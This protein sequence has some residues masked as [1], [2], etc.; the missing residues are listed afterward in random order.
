[1]WPLFVALTVL[2]AVIG[3]A[4][5]LAGESQG[6]GAAALL[7]AIFNLLAIVL[8][9]RPA[10]SLLRRR[11]KD[12]P[13]IVARDYAGSWL[14]GLATVAVLVA[15]IAH[16]PTITAHKAALRDAIVRAQ[17]WIGTRAPAEFR[18][19]LA[20]VDDFTIEPGRM[21]RICVL[22]DVRVRTYCVIVMTDLPFTRSVRFAG[23]EPNS[24]FAAGADS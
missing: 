9:A 19:H 12:L 24:I 16:H 11:R 5:P 10:A 17:A 13:A 4:L 8:L 1:M 22:S 20:V 15:G 3:H 21:F 23:Y 18:R 14:M 6:L 7:G 2:D